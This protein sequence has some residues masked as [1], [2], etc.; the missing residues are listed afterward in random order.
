MEWNRTSQRQS[1][2]G[3][4]AELASMVPLGVPAILPSS[5][6]MNGAQTPTQS[7]HTTR[8]SSR[9]YPVE[10]LAQEKDDSSGYSSSHAHSFR[11][12][13]DLSVNEKPLRAHVWENHHSC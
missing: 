5:A 11:S 9:S 13:H 4:D 2:S 12:Y 10:P 6:V 8:F 1:R 7:F 3:K